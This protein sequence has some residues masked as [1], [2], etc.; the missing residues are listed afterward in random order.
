MTNIRIFCLA[1]IYFDYQD[2]CF[3]SLIVTCTNFRFIPKIG[4]IQ[5]PDLEYALYE[6]AKRNV[7]QDFN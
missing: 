5:S 2:D 6:S 4:L 1:F 3:C 7:A